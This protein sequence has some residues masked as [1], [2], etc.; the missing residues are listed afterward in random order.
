MSSYEERV[1][2]LEARMRRMET[3]MQALLT[4]LGINPA[5]LEPQLPPLPQTIREALLAGDKMKAIKLYREMYGVSLKE[6]QDAIEG[7]PGNF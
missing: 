5:E 2:H 1:V 6:A 3:M 7:K 4:H